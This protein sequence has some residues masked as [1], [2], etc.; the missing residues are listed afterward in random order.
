MDETYQVIGVGW[1]V[2]YNFTSMVPDESRV[3]LFTEPTPYDDGS[4][5]KTREQYFKFIILPAVCY[6]RNFEPDQILI[7]INNADNK[8]LNEYKG[9]L[10]KV[11]PE[12]QVCL[13]KQT[14]EVELKE[15]TLLYI[16]RS[17][18]LSLIAGLTLFQLVIQWVR[19]SLR[20]FSVYYLCGMTSKDILWMIYGRLL[21]YYLAGG[22]VAALL[23]RVTLPVLQ[24]IYRE[25]VPSY[26]L[27]AMMLGLIFLLISLVSFPVINKEVKGIREG[28]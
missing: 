14:P 16:R 3:R 24:F 6:L 26:V 13:P 23:H 21:C 15:K 1:M 7:Q 27:L 9:K 18:I 4:S 19:T 22:I 17:L 20:E 25:E 2:S 11:F 12:A 5:G 10:E 8:K 28:I